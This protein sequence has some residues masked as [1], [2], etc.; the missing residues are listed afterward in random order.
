MK[1]AAALSGGVDSST[2]AALALKNGAEVIGVTLAMKHPDP[3]FSAMQRCSGE[4]D[5]EAVRAI[6]G[7]LGIPHVVLE[8][9][10]R[11]RD[12]VLRPAAETYIQ[13]RTPNPCCICNPMV[14]FAAL[15]EF[16]DRI[17]ADAVLTGHYARIEDGHLKRGVDPVKDQS[18][19][20]Y[21]LS[22]ETLARTL[23]PVGGM[24]KTA[25]RNLAAELDLPTAG[26]PDSQDACFM[27]EEESFGE[28]LRRLFVL[29]AAP[30]RF[31]HQGKVV[32]HHH[33]IH[34]YTIGQ[35]KG[36]G[37]ALGCRAY[38]REIRPDGDILLD[39]SEEHLFSRKFSLIDICGTVPE[40]GMVQIRY[41]AKPVPAA[42][43]D[44]VVLPEQPLRAVTPGQSAVF[45]S[46]DTVMGGGVINELY[47]D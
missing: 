37:V 32:G 39:T 29:P 18:Y 19:F 26:R 43:H 31:L 3:Q 2:A 14:K 24:P 33:G 15:M 1:I 30:G 22:P 27:A 38:I 40:S 10:P 9:F 35:R 45:Y 23:F 8:E 47:A 42:Y 21:R 36:M 25:V 28:T 17:G 11:F 16:A 4:A 34:E 12:K 20:L 13:G 5:L 7:K 41:R 6:C 46:G 44:G